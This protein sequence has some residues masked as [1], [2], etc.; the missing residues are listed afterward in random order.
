MSTGDGGRLVQEF[1]IAF[2]YGDCLISLKAPQFAMGTLLDGV[3][4]GIVITLPEREGSHDTSP[5]VAKDTVWRHLAR[6]LSPFS[7]PREK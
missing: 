6:A 1:S 2:N 7:Q 4:D 5:L 3:T